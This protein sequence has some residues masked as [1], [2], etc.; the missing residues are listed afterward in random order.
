[1][2]ATADVLAATVCIGAAL[3]G[4]P[5]WIWGLAP[6]PLWVLA[7]KFL[8]LYDRD[9]RVLRHLTI[10]EIPSILAWAAI[11]AVLTS[12]TLSLTPSGQLQ[13]A[14][15]AMLFV[16]LAVVDLLLRVAARRVWR[17]ITP[18]ARCLVIG[19][20]AE[21]RLLTRKLD[22]FADMHMV[23]A[24]VIEASQFSAE[25]EQDPAVPLRGVDRVVVAAQS[26]SPDLISRLAALCRVAQIKLSV[27]SALR[28]RAV[29][30]PTI[31]QLADLPVLEFDTG[32]ISRS[33]IALKRGF[34]VVVA[35]LA[36]TLTAPLMALIAIAIK[37]D[38]RGPVFF[39][40]LRAGLQ[41][42]PF[43]LFKFR[44]M[45]KDAEADLHEVVRL[46][47]LDEPVF[48]LRDDP[49]VT[50]VGRVLRK[51]SLDELPQFIN[52]LRG[53]MSVVGPRPEQVDLV[54]RY[55]PEQRLRL[56]VKPGITGPMQVH[57]RGE[58]TF[59]ERLALDLD[60]I[61]N[62]SLGRDLRIVALTIPTVLRRH[63]AY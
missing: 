20:A 51:L 52:A 9:H 18:P 2:L 23:E 14:D 24:G 1:M 55:N 25:I 44:T 28:G 57:G 27:I 63:G 5:G 56:E 36:L 48:K 53:E 59:A 12:A 39:R 22:L 45:H 58:L 62:L 4:D 35:A 6:F 49:R 54:E 33:S 13:V 10:D 7:A 46:D 30:A 47:E 43:L 29:P 26:L 50:R 38:S 61:E 11:V 40:Q 3:A 31:S 37:L 42:R 34:D 21:S 60:Y 19:D 17:R 16:G 15:L 41:G 8:G 32:D